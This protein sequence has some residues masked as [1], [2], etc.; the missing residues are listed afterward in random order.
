[1]SKYLE[2]ISL[3]SMFKS[4]VPTDTVESLVQIDKFR[5]ENCE[6]LSHIERPTAPDNTPTILGASDNN[7][8]L[9]SE[10]LIK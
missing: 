5:N 10:L 8:V 7:Y 3:Y 9:S 4:S 1:M 6:I 2:T